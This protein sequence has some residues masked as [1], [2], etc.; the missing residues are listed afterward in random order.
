MFDKKELDSYCKRL[1]L[2]KEGIKLLEQVRSSLPVRS[3]Q[4]NGGNWSGDHSSWKMQVTTQFESDTGERSLHNEYDYDPDVQEYYDQPLEYDVEYEVDGAIKRFHHI[5]DSL[6][7]RE[8]QVGFEEFKFESKLLKLAAKYP[9]RYVKEDGKWRCP[10]CEH[11]ARQ[12]GFY[13]RIRTE[14]EIN[15]VFQRNI[16][17]LKD[18]LRDL[19]PISGASINDIVT[20]IKNNPGITLEELFD[21]KGQSVTR[22]D[23]FAMIAARHI[24]VDLWASWLGQFDQARLFESKQHADSFKF[25][26]TSRPQGVVPSISIINVEAGST[27]VL[28]NTQYKILYTGEVIGLVSQDDSLLEISTSTFDNLIQNGKLTGI[29]YRANPENQPQSLEIWRQASP[30]ELIEAQRRHEILQRFLAGEP[31]T[32]VAESERTLYRWLS[33]YR[34]AKALYGQGFWG[35]VPLWGNSGNRTPRLRDEVVSFMEEFIKE[36]YETPKQI[37]KTIAYELFKVECEEK[38]YT[39]PS[40]KTFFR[41]IRKRPKYEQAKKRRGTKGA[42]KHKPFIFWLDRKTPRHGDRPFQIC[43]IDHTPLDVELGSV[44]IS[45]QPDQ[46][47]DKTQKA[48]VIL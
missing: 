40:E 25:L 37:T 20:L 30:K 6:V 32:N 44:D 34:E 39:P 10:P 4:G 3:V 11:E 18:Y 33:G 48:Q 13:Y 16:D 42:Y 9:G 15:P 27:V 38:G 8:N 35:L 14:A 19:P 17:L 46:G 22:D 28:G 47:T 5:P 36:K 29:N 31:L 45:T 41:A 1:G 43:H 24:Y 23:I 7:L 12:F 2:P 26:P 21:A